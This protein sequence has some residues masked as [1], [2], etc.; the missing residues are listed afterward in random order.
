VLL[1]EPRRRAVGYCFGR[2]VPLAVLAGAEIG[3]GEDFLETQHLHAAGAGLFDEGGMRLE[4]P[5]PDLLR[6]Q[7][8]VTLQAHL[9]Q[10]AL[11]FAHPPLPCSASM[12]RTPPAIRPMAVEFRRRG[13]AWRLSVGVPARHD[14]AQ[15]PGDAR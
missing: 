7:R 10:A 6:T 14:E 3:L 9:D 8:D 4:H 15:L 13:R 11:Q 1:H 5:L 12:V 2:R